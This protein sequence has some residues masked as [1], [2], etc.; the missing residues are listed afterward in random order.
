LEVHGSSAGTTAATIAAFAAVLA[1]ALAGISVIGGEAWK[2]YLRRRGIAALISEDLH[3]WE[4][5]IVEAYYRGI[6]WQQGALLKPQSE[7]G[8]LKRA[9]TALRPKEW[10][11]LSSARRWVDY[12]EA[13]RSRTAP[14]STTGTVA[15]KEEERRWMAETFYRLEA[16]RWAL[17]RQSSP[18]SKRRGHRWQSRWKGYRQQQ[19]ALRFAGSLAPEDLTLTTLDRSHVAD[20][21]ALVV[22][23]VSAHVT[24]AGGAHLLPAAVSGLRGASTAGPAL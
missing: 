1:A 22:D 10:S 14:D 4:G 23:G 6:W 7:P 3:R 18:F 2:N 24:T 15:L 12:L 16:A 9:A 17:L 13:V 11:A 21:E 5:T 19:L 20:L 8:D